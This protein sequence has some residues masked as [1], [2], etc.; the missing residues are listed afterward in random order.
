LIYKTNKILG[1]DRRSLGSGAVPR[2]TEMR[3]MQDARS[4]SRHEWLPIWLYK[5]RCILRE[6]QNYS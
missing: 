3:L 5:I 6:Q 1:V 4:W 2:R